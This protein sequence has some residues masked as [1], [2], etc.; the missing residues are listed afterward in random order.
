MNPLTLE[1]SP[2]DAAY[3]ASLVNEALTS[4]INWS[5]SFVQLLQVHRLSSG[6]FLFEYGYAATEKSNPLTKQPKKIPVDLWDETTRLHKEHSSLRI[7]QEFRESIS[8][9][10]RG[11]QLATR[12]GGY[13]HLNRSLCQINANNDILLH[14]DPLFSVDKRVLRPLSW[15]FRCRLRTGGSI[16]LF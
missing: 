3:T 13:V 11:T 2:N 9:P 6:F 12:A 8:G 10:L 14:M 4:S 16:P 1:R 7:S 15:H 5:A